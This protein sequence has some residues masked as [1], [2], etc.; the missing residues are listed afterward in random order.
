M[1]D[2]PQSLRAVFA[3]AE[4]KRKSL[5]LSW[6]TNAPAYQDTL[7]AAISQYHRC[8]QLSDS[9]ALFSSNESLDDIATNDLQ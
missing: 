3:S 7:Q 5:E 6:E 9:V 8:L 4:A 2:E 1:A